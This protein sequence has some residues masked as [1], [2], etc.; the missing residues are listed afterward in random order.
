MGIVGAAALGLGGKAFATSALGKALSGA[1]KVQAIGGGKNNMQASFMDLFKK[2]EEENPVGTVQPQ[3]TTGVE[4]TKFPTLLPP[5]TRLNPYL[6]DR[7][8]ADP[9]ALPPWR[10]KAMDEAWKWG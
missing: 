8:S 3:I 9:N 5:D 6:P 1:M 4:G 7:M 2:D 10:Q